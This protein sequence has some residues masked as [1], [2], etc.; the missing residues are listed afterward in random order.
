MAFFRITFK[1]KQSNFFSA[2]YELINGIEMFI[3]IGDSALVL[4]KKPFIIPGLIKLV[5]KFF[6][7][8]QFPIIKIIDI[9]QKIPKGE[10]IILDTK[11]GK[12]V[13]TKI[14]SQLVLEPL[15]EN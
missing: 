8:S 13:L 12:K 14:F 3:F 7:C 15:D 5:P 2:F 10:K 6:R 1:T 9:A 4:M 11:R